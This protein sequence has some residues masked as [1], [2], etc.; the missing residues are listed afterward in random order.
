MK[1]IQNIRVCTKYKRYLNTI[2]FSFLLAFYEHTHLGPSQSL[3]R[4]LFF[5]KHFFLFASR[6]IKMM[7]NAS[8]F[9][10]KAFSVLE[11]FTFL[12]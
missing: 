9:M 1:K 10:L 11:I 5:Q 8:Y 7:R 12:S 6:P 2:C 3:S 4:P